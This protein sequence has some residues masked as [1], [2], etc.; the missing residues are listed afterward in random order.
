MPF[1]LIRINR[2]NWRKI[3]S[4][5][6]NGVIETDL[7]A[8]VLADLKTSSN[9]YQ[10]WYI[11]VAKSNLGQITAKLTEDSTIPPDNVLI[12]LASIEAIGLTLKPV[13]A[14][15]EDNSR[16]I[17]KLSAVKLVELSNIIYSAAEKS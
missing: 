15:T 17:D 2:E 11:D 10:V 14:I 12:D 6:T 16:W 8:D 4:K 9:E 3:E 7:Q 13:D 5:E 1:L